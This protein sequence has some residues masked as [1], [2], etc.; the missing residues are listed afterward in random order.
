MT[1][2][3][4]HRGLRQRRQKNPTRP[5]HAF[6]R[7]D[8]ERLPFLPSWRAPAVNLISESADIVRYPLIGDDQPIQEQANDNVNAV[9]VKVISE[10]T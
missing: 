6:R 1:M 4:Q 10:A 9:T 7:D 5:A 2:P 8:P 3:R